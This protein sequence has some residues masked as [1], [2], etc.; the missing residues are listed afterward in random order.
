MRKDYE[1]FSNY[2]KP[3]SKVID[4]GCG[5]G[6]FLDYL[7]AY[8]NCLTHGI[9]VD[10]GNVALAM[11]KGLSV[12][13]GDADI[14]LSFYPSKNKTDKPFDYA[15]LANTI[16]AIKAPDKVLEQAKRIAKE[17][18]IST[19]NFA[20]IE[21]RKYFIFKG[22][23][24]VTKQLPYEWYNTPNIHFSTIRDMIILLKEKGF[25]IKQLYYVT[26]KGKVKEASEDFLF[27]ANLFGKMGVYIV[28]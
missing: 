8:K 27:F 14:D 7:K 3:N 13:H 25:S 4:I 22:M 2:I 1:I 28:S 6:D 18:L 5:E 24:P 23:M 9:D 10:S 26:E 17:V 11:N 16:Q 20:Y 12:I 15:I 19:P 21:N